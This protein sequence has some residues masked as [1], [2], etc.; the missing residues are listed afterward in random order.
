MLLFLLFIIQFAGER[1]VAAVVYSGH[2]IFNMADVNI[3][4][5]GNKILLRLISSD[6]YSVKQFFLS[7]EV[8]HGISTHLN[9]EQGDFLNFHKV[10]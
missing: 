10:V 6:K 4:L 3:F 7:G 1:L 9:L 8:I 2:A 5:L